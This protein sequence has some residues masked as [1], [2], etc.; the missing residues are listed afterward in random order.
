V[1]VDID[2]LADGIDGTLDRTGDRPERPGHLFVPAFRASANRAG[3]RLYRRLWWAV[4]VPP[5]ELR[6]DR[7]S[8]ADPP[9]A[10]VVP[11][12]L[13]AEEARVFARV[14]LALAF[15]TRDLT[16]AQVARVR[17]QFL[18]GE[19]EGEPGLAYLTVPPGLLGPFRSV[20][21]RARP[22]AVSR[23]EGDDPND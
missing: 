6:D 3:V 9:P 19:L 10:E 7:F 5:R 15:G 13:P 11:I 8:P 21:G 18:A 16:R 22:R 12:T 14:Y 1:I 23:L 17:E 4:Q 2:R 20:L